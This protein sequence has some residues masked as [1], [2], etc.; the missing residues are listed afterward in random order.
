M[1]TSTPTTLSWNSSPGESS[2]PAS[3]ERRTAV[4]GPPVETRLTPGGTVLDVIGDPAESRITALVWHGIEPN[5]RATVRRLALELARRRRLVIVPD[6]VSYVSDGG[7]AAMLDSYAYA[8]DAF[9]A[10]VRRLELWGWSY[11]AAAAMAFGFLER[12]DVSRIVGLAGRYGSPTPFSDHDTIDLV[13]RVDHR[14]DLVHGIHDTVT[15]PE[16][17]EDM[18]LSMA[19]AGIEG[20]FSFPATDHAGVVFAALHPD[21]DLS[22]PI[23]GPLDGHPMTDALDDLL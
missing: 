8:N 21:L 2:N 3:R 15:P 12:P 18:G 5:G 22:L 23:S 20:K 19:R 1:P 4:T 9:D 11:G 13:R 7:R 14:V 17:S 10:G 16:S 6:H